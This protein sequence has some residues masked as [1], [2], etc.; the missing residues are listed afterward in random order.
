MYYGRTPKY[1]VH[2][3]GCQLNVSDGEKLKGQLE[4]MGYVETGAVEDADFVIYNTC[5]VRENAEDRAFGN[6]GALKNQ[7][8][9]RPSMLIAICGCMTQQQHNADRIKKSFPFVDIVFGTHAMYRLPEMVCSRL[10]GRGRVFET[11]E[12]NCDIVEG[13]PVHR[14]SGFKAWLPIMYGCDNFCSYCIVPYVRGRERSRRPEE[15]VKEARQI[16]ESGY[17]EIMLLGQNVN[18]YG[19]GLEE[20]INF[21]ELLRRIDA[22]EGDYRIRFMTSHPK[23]CT[24]ELI[25][26]IAESKHV[27]HHIHLPVQCGSNRILKLMNRRYTVEKYIELI[28]YAREKIP[29]VTFTSDIIVGF[30]GET[31]EDFCLTLELLKRVR[32]NALYTFIYSKREGT[33]AA[34]MEDPIPYEDK[35]RWFREL[36]AV[37]EEIAESYYRNM[38]GKRVRVL[39]EELG[40]TEGTITGRDDGNNIVNI[41]A[42]ES[43]IGSFVEV[44]ID[45]AFNWA[46]G[47]TVAE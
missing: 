46:V 32:F 28:D 5:A 17:K 8:R 7:K 43:L 42:P 22:I 18:S 15:V 25:D 26:T 13:M 40:K 29:D 24:R 20:N 36:L 10:M 35:S 23:D 2:S 16:V 44:D 9:R 38:V 3:Y 33:V 19:V 27:C 12:N 4:A 34:K 1:H 47:G 14:D 30:P 6:L 21:S 31:Y 11:E 39:P 45:T 37:Q 41:K